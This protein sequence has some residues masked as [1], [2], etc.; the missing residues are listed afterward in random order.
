MLN[1]GIDKIMRCMDPG[2]IICWQIHTVFKCQYQGVTCWSAQARLWRYLHRWWLQ[3]W[4][5]ANDR[6]L[7]L[8]TQ[9]LSESWLWHALQHIHAQ[10][11]TRLPR[12]LTMRCHPLVANQND[13]ILKGQEVFHM[14]FVARSYLD[15][16]WLMASM[17]HKGCVAMHGCHLAIITHN[18]YGDE[19]S[20]LAWTGRSQR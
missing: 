20:L 6:R 16:Q 17:A 14:N 11:A 1:A 12:I 13:S 4:W 5:T 2:S 19:D 9:A 8:S 3:S 10:N 7:V 18:T 15:G